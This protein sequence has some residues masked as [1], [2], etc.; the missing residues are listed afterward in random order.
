MVSKTGSKELKGTKQT[1]S[2]F[3]SGIW[4]AMSTAAA[5]QSPTK[6]S[7]KHKGHHEAQQLMLGTEARQILEGN[8]SSVS[9]HTGN[10]ELSTH[11]LLMEYYSLTWCPLIWHIFVQSCK[12]VQ[13]SILTQQAQVDLHSPHSHHHHHQ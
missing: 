11:M 8:F 4:M 6:F 9:M 13:V 10:K 5:I 7:I 12:T 3:L 2:V 1:A